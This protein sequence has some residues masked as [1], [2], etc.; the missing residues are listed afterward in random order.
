MGLFSKILGGGENADKAE[1]MAK[2]LLKGIMNG[3]VSAEKKDE[4]QPQQSAPSSYAPTQGKPKQGFSWGDVKPD[5]ENQFDYPGP[6]YEY[7]K[8]IYSEEFPG[9][10]L[11]CEVVNEGARAAIAFISDD[12]TAL[13][14]ELVSENSTADKLRRRCKANGIPYLRFY[15]NHHGWW[16]TR[17][18]VVERTRKALGA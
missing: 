8:K 14:V 15:H 13:M 6:Y 1:Q 4:Q 5:E 10:D 9:Y 7:F 12:R 16:N 11:R 18:Y 17:A 2:D 3:A